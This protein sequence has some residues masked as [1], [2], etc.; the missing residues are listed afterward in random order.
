[1]WATTSLKCP[2][3]EDWVAVVRVD[4]DG[5]TTLVRYLGAIPDDVERELDAVQQRWT[6]RATWP[7]D[8]EIQEGARIREYAKYPEDQA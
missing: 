1:M 5:N 6:E 8:A 7:G 2:D 4:R 3:S